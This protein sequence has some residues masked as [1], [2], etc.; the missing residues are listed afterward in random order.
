[1]PSSEKGYL[2]VV[3]AALRAGV[4]VDHVNRLGWTA[5]LEAVILG[6]GGF[7]YQEIV[8]ELMRAQADVTIT[9]FSGKNALD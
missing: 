6:D 4:P 2:K 8:L 1:M 5:L 7:L 3:Q 9:D